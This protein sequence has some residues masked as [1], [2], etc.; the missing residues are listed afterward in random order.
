MDDYFS[1]GKSS[2]RGFGF[3]LVLA[4]HALLI[5]G[6]MS[7]LARTVVDKIKEPFD[8][9]EIDEPPPP[10][11]EIEP[12]PPP[13]TVEPPPFV[14]PPEFDIAISSAPSE[15][16]I[17]EATSEKPPPPGP[18]VPVRP[19]PRRPVTQ[20]EY[21]PSAKRLEQEGVVGLLLLVGADGRVQEVQVETSSG[22]PALDNAA[23]RE[24]RSWRF[25]PA[26]DAGKP[27]AAWHRLKVRFRLEDA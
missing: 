2:R 4:F 5:W 22:F 25:L 17:T 7:G 1:K 10:E 20:P 15:T 27:I 12:P 23:A 14:P 16:A 8:V 11:E 3:I 19:D 9:A 13:P 6:L 18:T 26:Q 24:A 21:P